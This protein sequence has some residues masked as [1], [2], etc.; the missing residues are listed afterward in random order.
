MREIQQD[1]GKHKKVR[2][3]LDRSLMLELYPARKNNRK[4]EEGREGTHEHFMGRLQGNAR[5]P[6]TR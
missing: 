2:A 3:L 1:K 4:K 5:Q 6:G